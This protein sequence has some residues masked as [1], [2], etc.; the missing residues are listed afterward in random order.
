MKEV[1]YDP[2]LPLDL[3]VS[4]GVAPAAWLITQGIE[5]REVALAEIV[6]PS[7]EASTRKCAN[8]FRRL[9]PRHT[10]GV[11]LRLFG[12]VGKGAAFSDFEA[13]RAEF[14]RLKPMYRTTPY[15][16]KDRVNAVNATLRNRFGD[17]SGF[18]TPKCERL[19][20]DLEGT[21]NTDASYRVDHKQATLGHYA[22]AWGCKLLRL[23]PAIADTARAQ[24][25]VGPVSGS[26]FP[27]STP[28]AR[29]AYAAIQRALANGTLRRPENCEACR[30][31]CKPD[32]AHF[33]YAEPLRV[34][35][36][37]RP[38]HAAWDAEEPKGGTLSG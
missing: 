28:E 35:W 4:F 26:R 37:C 1:V 23:Y 36:L 15:D 24:R 8:E 29:R 2:A 3:C 33:N 38:C 17:V 13:I 31:L 21:R 7:G 34:R 32:A 6:P 16:E 22:A 18:A 25:E 12:E 30:K 20:R 11:N 27:E 19:I 5:G 9:F 14:P 10:V